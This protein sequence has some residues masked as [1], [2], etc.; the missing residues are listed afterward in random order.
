MENKMKKLRL[1][2]IA[3]A[4][5]FLFPP[6]AMARSLAEINKTQELRICT[7]GSS[8]EYYEEMG[9][10]FAKWLN[11]RAT[12]QNLASWD[13]QFH[14]DDGVTIREESYTPK[15]LASGECDC[16]PNDLVVN[17]W[18]KTKMTLVPLYETR[19]VVLVHKDNLDKFQSRNSL[20]GHT[21][22]VMKNTSYHTW[23]DEQNQTD[24]SRH[25]INI[26]FMQT[27]DAW[28]AVSKKQIDFTL[29]NATT[30]F[31]ELAGRAKDLRIAF[32]VGP[33]NQLAWG[34]DTNNETLILAAKLFVKRQMQ[35]NSDFDMIWLE[36]GTSIADYT[37]LMKTFSEKERQGGSRSRVALTQEE[38]DFL[39]RHPLILVHNE[40][41]WAPF[42][43]NTDGTPK[44]FSIDYMNLL[45]QTLGIE[46]QFING[47]SWDE[48]MELA[49]SGAIDVMLNIAKTP[50]RETF[51]EFT[52]PYVHMVQRLYTRKDFPHVNSVRDL[53][54]KRFAVPKG[55]YLQEIL[56]KYPDVKVIEVKNTTEAINAVSVGRADAFFDLMPVVNYLMEQ[57]QITNIK[58]GGDLDISEGAPIPLHIGVSR[59]VAPLS[60]I[61]EK[62]MAAVPEEKLLLLRKK[63]LGET[64]VIIP[65]VRLSSDEKKW[66][67]D[68]GRPLLVANELD[69]PPFDFAVDGQAKGLSIDMIRLAAKKAGLDLKFV[70]GYSWSQLAEKFKAK[71]IDILPAVYMTSDRK[72]YMAFT[73][74]YATNPSVAVVRSDRTDIKTLGDLNGMTVGV[75]AGFATADVMKERYPDIKQQVVKNV[76]DG[77]KA[78]SLKHVD[79]F[80][81]SMG[82]ISHILDTRV[83]PDLWILDEMS[84]K[85]KEETNLHMAVLKENIIL[86]NILQK[87]LDAFTI[88][89][90]REL[91]RRWLPFF[92]D[93][94][95]K[96][97]TL[98]TAKERRWL[99]EHKALKLGDD[100]A[101]RP[102]TFLDEN[103]RFTGIAAGYTDA[104]S[105]RLG[106]DFV[107][108]T[109]LTWKAVVEEIKTGALDIL[110]AVTP[111]QAHKKFLHFTQ[112][113]ISFPIVIATRKDGV[114]VDSL[115]DLLG[116]EV[117]VVAGDITWEI[118]TSDFPGL[119]LVP[120][121]SVADG[122]NALDRKKNAAFIGDLGSI[123]YEIESGKLD[124]IKI[125]A[126]TKYRFELCIGVRKEWPQLAVILDK[127]LGTIDDKERSAIK[128][129]WMA[130]E[131]NYGIDLRT[132]ILWVA[133][134]AVS[135]LLVIGFVMVWNR[136]LGKEIMERK[137]AEKEV[138]KSQKL[139][140]DIINSLPFWLSVKDTEGQFR[141]IN[142]L[143]VESTTDNAA[144]VVGS[145]SEMTDLD[146]QVLNHG[147]TVE[148]PEYVT[149]TPDGERFR[150]MLKVPWKDIDGQV[151]GVIAWSED[152]TERKKIRAQRDDAFQVIKSSINYAGTIQR[153]VLPTRQTMQEILGNYFVLWEPRDVVGGDIYWCQHWGQGGLLLLGDCTGHGV[154]GAFMTLI[155]SGALDRA[156][157][158][159]EPGDAAGL[160]SAMH[161]I[162]QR[163]LV[164]DLSVADDDHCSD[165]G[166]EMGA[167]FIPAEKDKLIFAGAGFPLFCFDGNSVSKIKGDR[168]GIGYRHIIQ[169]T[170]WTNTV[171]QV[172]PGLRFYM[173]SDGIFDQIGGPK[174][175]GFGKKRFMKL[176]ESVQ[177]LPVS[178]QGGA[179][180]KAFKE[181]QGTA[182]RRDDVSAAGF[183]I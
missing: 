106:I 148:I 92:E 95:G 1:P 174:Q 113:Y 181:Y 37:D 39:A 23:L 101:R 80:I 180:Y 26:E 107:P 177:T 47:P 58:V 51:L 94:Q 117:G 89:E 60:G 171:L 11:V 82:V 55:F 147:K 115:N 110:P 146:Y 21:A 116:K 28:D 52:P 29:C 127:A 108:K 126:P 77:L 167:C 150:R 99:S 162:V 130:I 71:E 157:M 166:L 168:K 72:T 103:N 163:S 164:Q 5:L 69:W 8:S 61:L 81:G 84:L 22:A 125:A 143:Q 137:K 9:R 98:L 88:E 46:V 158:T 112:P 43:F 78:V 141:L 83:I 18:R 160:I 59:K 121:K 90:L 175:R 169:E 91:R 34:F 140:E 68:K 161:K 173:S 118:M 6:S 178:Q 172:R 165:D 24:F 41:D 76:E 7:A 132:I 20:R 33:A 15:L 152:I 136:R 120:F 19:T 79:A 128:N 131:V 70:N 176:V 104:L 31:K 156:L 2:L 40:S 170:T 67:S 153:S 145:Q 159:V 54:D 30:V 182:K 12:V 50:E 48:F 62:A 74:P 65:G 133:P 25:P 151:N 135:A 144:P 66:I 53:A 86:R 149:R 138:R 75:V 3:L 32:A 14:N 57:L 38:A 142:K 85:T 105:K 10:V 73:S 179:I 97:Y 35:K 154:P 155:A 183:E 134:F 102:F 17:E 87:G 4:I 13:H 27:Y 111:T 42:N 100:F 139:M 45:A 63:W 109:G 124:D 114:F 119:S 16:Y 64:S 93:S 44:G 96:L 49:K 36:K 122:L 56:K 123:T 129:A